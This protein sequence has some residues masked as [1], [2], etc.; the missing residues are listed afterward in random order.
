MTKTKLAENVISFFCPKCKTETT[1]LNYN[2]LTIPSLV[3]CLKCDTP[4]EITELKRARIPFY[5]LAVKV[6]HG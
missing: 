6:A 1:R 5:F 3:I 2:E 4:L